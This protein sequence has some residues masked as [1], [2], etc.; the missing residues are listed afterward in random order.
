MRG[1]RKKSA[2]S[3]REVCEIVRYVLMGFVSELVEVY[4][5]RRSAFALVLKVRDYHTEI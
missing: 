3:P 5:F 4:I 2:R 1:L